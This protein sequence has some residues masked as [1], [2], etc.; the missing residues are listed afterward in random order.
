MDFKKLEYFI[1]EKMAQMNTAGI[2]MALV[3]GNEVVWSRGFG[4]RDVAQRLPATSGTIYDVA[5]V[6]KSF[7]AVAIL[8]LQEQGKLSLEDP[9]TKFIPEFHIKP[10]GET[11]KIKHLLT[12]TSGLPGLVRQHV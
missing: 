3:A 6:T 12:H 1:F 2:S 8:Q 4:F 10:F 7:S 5:S 9:V 11:I